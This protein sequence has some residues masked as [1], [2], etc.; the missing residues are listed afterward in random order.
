MLMST[1]KCFN[2]ELNVLVSSDLRTANTRDFYVPKSAF[3][4]L[5]KRTSVSVPFIA[6]AEDLRKRDSTAL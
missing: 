1:A 3:H 5:S 4:T 2:L 6:R